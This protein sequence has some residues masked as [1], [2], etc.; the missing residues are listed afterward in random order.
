[1]CRFVFAV[2]RPVVAPTAMSG[3]ME[4]ASLM[5]LKSVN[6]A[7]SLNREKEHARSGVACHVLLTP[8]TGE[9]VSVSFSFEATPPQLVGHGL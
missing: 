2:V 7:E 6:V 3:L 5:N 1:M 8:S 4:L 9:T